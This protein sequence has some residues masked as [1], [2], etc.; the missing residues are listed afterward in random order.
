MNSLVAIHLE[1]VPEF[2]KEVN[3]LIEAGFIC[4][5]KYPTWIVSV[6]PI[7]KKNEQLHI[8]VDFWDLND[9]SPKDNYRLNY[10][11]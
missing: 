7:R 5:I 3:K 4:D 10:R 11:A 6:M 1:F 9:A 2:K 8:Y